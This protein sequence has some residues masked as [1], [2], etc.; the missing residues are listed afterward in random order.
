M[1]ISMQAMKFALRALVTVTTLLSVACVTASKPVGSEPYVLDP[2]K[3]SGT[4]RLAGEP[5]QFTVSIPEGEPGVLVR[6]SIDEAG[7]A[8]T[9]RVLLRTYSG[10]IFASEESKDHPGR[11]YWGR[12]KLDGDIALFWQPDE[13][14]FAD[15]VESG[16]LPGTSHRSG[17]PLVT[18]D[19]EDTNASV[20]LGALI[21]W[22]LDV[23]ASEKHGVLFKWDS[24]MVFIRIPE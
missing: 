2:S 21:D 5:G 16:V 22:H 4:W 19:R 10:W 20:H 8:E 9:S 23:I 11:F 12:L 14:K 17:S 18:D 7:A 15:L 3:W 6:H 24:P 1:R 13:E